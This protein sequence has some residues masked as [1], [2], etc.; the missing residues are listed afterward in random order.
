M[1]APEVPATSFIRRKREVCAVSS[2]PL[3][4]TVSQSRGIEFVERKY[5]VGILKQKQAAI[6]LRGYILRSGRRIPKSQSRSRWKLHKIRNPHSHPKSSNPQTNSFPKVMV[7]SGLGLIW[8]IRHRQGVSCM[9][10]YQSLRVLVVVPQRLKINILVTEVLLLKVTSADPIN[11]LL[12]TT[13]RSSTRPSTKDFLRSSTKLYRWCY[14]KAVT[15]SIWC[16]LVTVD[17]S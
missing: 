17:F 12:A 16:N 1:S 3:V 7:R 4:L 8:C 5:G 13:G 14:L 11:S 15:Y 6:R 2:L 10:L 9:C